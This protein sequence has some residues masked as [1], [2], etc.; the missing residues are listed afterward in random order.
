[1]CKGRVQLIQFWRFLLKGGQKP[2]GCHWNY[3][4][5]SDHSVCT[6]VFG[7]WL[8]PPHSLSCECEREK[9][10]NYDT[11]YVP[12][13]PQPFAT[14]LLTM[15]W[16][17]LYTFALWWKRNIVSY[18]CKQSVS[19]IPFYCITDAGL[20]LFVFFPVYYWAMP[21]SLIWDCLH[22]IS[23]LWHSTYMYA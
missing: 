21:C 1:M 18:L 20:F 10:Q 14:I 19:P 22:R 8:L 6:W 17:R 15:R 3:G 11:W 12:S 2:L 5:P 16:Q 23:T 4:E 7:S 9:K 13:H